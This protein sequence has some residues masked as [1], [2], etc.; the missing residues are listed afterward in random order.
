[1]HVGCNSMRYYRITEFATMIG[2]SAST[3]RSWD[4][5]NIFKPCHRSPT[6]YRYYSDE[7]YRQ[8]LSEGIQR[9]AKGG[10]DA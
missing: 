10:A 6:G 1:M 5:L 8:Y 3:L 4:E 9:V 7:Q 2:V